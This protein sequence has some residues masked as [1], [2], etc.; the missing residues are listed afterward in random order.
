MIAT[1]QQVKSLHL[2]PELL[3]TFFNSDIIEAFEQR[4]VDGVFTFVPNHLCLWFLVIN[5]KAFQSKGIFEKALL[6]SYAA[7]NANNH[8]VAIGDLQS[9]FR[10]CDRDKLL[11]AGDQLPDGK[12]FTVYR[13]VSGTG[14]S[15][16]VRSYSWT[17]DHERAKWFSE[18]FS[19][20]DQAVYRAQ[21]KREQILCFIQERKE[22][23]VIVLPSWKQIERVTEP[24]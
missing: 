11:G 7:T 20:P 9:M 4:D 17:L 18:R 16:R 1:I 24:D 13:G 23:E 10:R 8:Q 21:V 3:G 2:D 12:E 5:Q 19:L 22:S 6:H 14:R 15:R